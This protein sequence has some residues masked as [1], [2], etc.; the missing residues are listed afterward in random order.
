MECLKRREREEIMPETPLLMPR[1]E[2][3]PTPEKRA[4]L[5]VAPE[6]L[7]LL[8][9]QEALPDFAGRLAEYL[10]AVR[11][12]ETS[13]LWATKIHFEP[14]MR[15]LLSTGSKAQLTLVIGIKEGRLDKTRS[16]HL[17]YSYMNMC[18]VICRALPSK[19]AKSR[20]LAVSKTADADYN[21]ALSTVR[22]HAEALTC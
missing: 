22:L 14:D 20:K 19:W 8:K 5:K 18:E 2:L 1:E 9:V 15:C 17:N 13:S 6:P 11:S 21:F 7:T 4:R 3:P 12:E 16:S 10:W